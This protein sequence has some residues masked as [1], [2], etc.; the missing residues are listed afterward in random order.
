MVDL[1]NRIALSK[2]VHLAILDKFESVLPDAWGGLRWMG[3][4]HGE[5]RLRR[6]QPCT[7]RSHCRLQERLRR[8]HT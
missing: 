4:R 1:Q 6:T 5:R 8:R 3:I 7:S 2:L